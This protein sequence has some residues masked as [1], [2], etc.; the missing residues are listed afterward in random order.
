MI[1]QVTC[2]CRYTTGIKHYPIFL[3]W[4]IKQNLYYPTFYYP[5]FQLSNLNPTLPIPFKPVILDFLL[6]DL[7]VTLQRGSDNRGSIVLQR[8]PLYL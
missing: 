3:R 4:I 8:V 6:S 7:I 1:N 2:N 5:N